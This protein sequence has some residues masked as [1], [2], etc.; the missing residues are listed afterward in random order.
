MNFHLF[1]PDQ[2]TSISYG[3][4]PHWYQPGITYLVTF[5]TSDSVPAALMDDWQDRRRAWLRERGFPES[6]LTDD[7]PLA[8][9][10]E[11]H[12]AFSAEFLE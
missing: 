6:V 9:R 7:L 11:Y 1:D 8:V 3:R 4:L 12:R 2:D 10:C 5:R